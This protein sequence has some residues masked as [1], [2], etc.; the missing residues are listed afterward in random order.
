MPPPTARI[1]EGFAKSPLTPQVIEVSADNW[2]KWD[3]LFSSFNHQRVSLGR[4]T[5]P[6]LTVSMFQKSAQTFLIQ[7]SFQEAWGPDGYM[8]SSI[9]LFLVK[10]A[11]RHSQMDDRAPSPTGH[12]M[13]RIGWYDAE[14]ARV[15]ASPSRAKW[16][17]LTL[18]CATCI[19]GV[20]KGCGNH[21]QTTFGEP[22]FDFSLSNGQTAS[23]AFAV[24]AN[25]CDECSLC[26]ISVTYYSLKCVQD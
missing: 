8:S 6:N 10:C 18:T 11:N 4:L 26:V 21:I 7:L 22:G 12:E 3:V 23:H 19:E 5:K 24:S 1:A 16:R 9:Y 15:Y 17:A 20:G 14:S 2:A 13:D 25:G